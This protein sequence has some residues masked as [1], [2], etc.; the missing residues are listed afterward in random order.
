MLKNIDTGLHEKI[1]G[2]LLSRET[3]SILSNP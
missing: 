1:K 2:L 3:P